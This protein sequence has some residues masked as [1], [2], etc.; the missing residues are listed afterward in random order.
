VHEV[1]LDKGGRGEID[2]EGPF[3]FTVK[4]EGVSEKQTVT[5]NKNYFNFWSAYNKK[6][7]NLPIRNCNQ[8]ICFDVSSNGDVYFKYKK[9]AL[10]NILSLAALLFV[11]VTDILRYGVVRNRLI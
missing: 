2:E 5:L 6:G 4:L 8:K 10:L 11:F 9:N 1:R 7:E 3:S